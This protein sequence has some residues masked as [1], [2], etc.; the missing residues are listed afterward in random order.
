[1]ATAVPHAVT[2]GWCFVNFIHWQFLC[3]RGSKGIEYFG[4][5]RFW[6]AQANLYAETWAAFTCDLQSYKIR[7]SI[8]HLCFTDKTRTNVLVTALQQQLNTRCKQ[9]MIYKF[10]RNLLT[11][12]DSIFFF[13]GGGWWEHKSSS[14]GSFLSWSSKKEERGADLKV[15]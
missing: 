2:S 7:N 1:M 12:M 13:L 11:L 10:A 5:F 4:C 15:C 6:C 8:F 14:W 9:K 3:S